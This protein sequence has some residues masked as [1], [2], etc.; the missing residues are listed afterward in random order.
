MAQTLFFTVV[1]PAYN[2]PEALRSCLQALVGQDFDRASFEVIV[3]DDGSLIPLQSVLDAFDYLPSIKFIR[4]PNSGPAIARNVGAAHARGR[5]VAFTDDDCRPSPSWLSCLAMRISSLPHSLV[6]GYTVNALPGNLFSTASQML[7][8]SMYRF[9]NANPDSA[10][11]VASNNICLSVAQFQSLGGF[12]RRFRLAAAEDRDFC[13]RWLEDQRQIVFA[14]E[15]QVF[16]AHHLSLGSFFAQHYHY[17][18]G[19]FFFRADRARRSRSA[20]QLEP[21]GF[22]FGLLIDP[23]RQPSS[24]FFVLT[25]LLVALAQVANAVG[26]FREALYGSLP[27]AN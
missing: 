2:R 8:D 17:G 13:Y 5:F 6:G 15:A 26:F 21:L 7:I 22:Y 3:V 14:P 19:A 24:Q 10:R 16:H 9:Y 27:R 4:Q 23:L 25:A 18:R 1:V 11:F 12:D 20:L